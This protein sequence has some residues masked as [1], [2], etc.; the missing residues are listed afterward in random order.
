MGDWMGGVKHNGSFKKKATKAGQSTL[1]Y[2]EQE[3][4]DTKNP[5]TMHQAQ[6]AYNMI[7]ITHHNHRR[8]RS[9]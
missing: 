1:A 9:K 7:K 2:A 3:R 8:G 5:K 6:A 4:H